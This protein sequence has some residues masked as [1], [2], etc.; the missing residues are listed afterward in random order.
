MARLGQA[1]LEADLGVRT[2]EEKENSSSLQTIFLTKHKVISENSA[3]QYA[4]DTEEFLTAW[5][6]MHCS[7]QGADDSSN[8]TMHVGQ[9]K[10]FKG[11]VCKYPRN[12]RSI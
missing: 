1:Q 7:L 4:S 2:V 8:T 9:V 12:A 6:Y 10:L 11:T 3:L 5:Y